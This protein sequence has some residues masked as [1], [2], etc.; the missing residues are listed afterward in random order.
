MPLWHGCTLTYVLVVPPSAQVLDW[1]FLN[2]LRKYKSPVRTRRHHGTLLLSRYEA[3]FIAIRT[4]IARPL[5]LLRWKLPAPPM[6]CL[7]IREIVRIR[8]SLRGSWSS[9]Q[10]IWRPLTG[11]SR[12]KFDQSCLLIAT[13]HISLMN[14]V[15]SVSQN[16]NKLK[17]MNDWMP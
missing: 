1:N 4:L 2:H 10:E 15:R 8:Y 17:K 5:I 7:C 3:D 9:F 12:G 11:R 14:I 6:W 16:I 13:I